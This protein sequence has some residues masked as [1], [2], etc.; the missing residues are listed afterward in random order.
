MIVLP[1]PLVAGHCVANDVAVVDN[2]TLSEHYKSVL[3]R[4]SLYKGVIG[5]MA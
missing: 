3:A 1:L 5:G 2:D 4:L